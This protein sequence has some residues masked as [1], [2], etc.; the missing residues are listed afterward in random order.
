MLFVILG[1]VMAC[2]TFSTLTRAGSTWSTL[3]SLTWRKLFMLFR[4]ACSCSP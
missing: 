1:S 4:N 3:G 2:G